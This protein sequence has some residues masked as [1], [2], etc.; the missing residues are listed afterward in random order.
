M[1]TNEYKVVLSLLLK[2]VDRYGYDT[3]YNKLTVI[4]IILWQA[5]SV[6]DDQYL[7]HSSSIAIPSQ[8]GWCWNGIF[9]YYEKA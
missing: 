9:M 1:S 5:F 3:S 8:F 4:I 2:Y 7:L 6:E